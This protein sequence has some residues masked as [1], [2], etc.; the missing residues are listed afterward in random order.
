M[1]PVAAKAKQREWA[2]ESA[3]DPNRTLVT[4]L[5]A[6]VQRSS[7][8]RWRVALYVKRL[9]NYFL[10]VNST[11]TSKPSTLEISVSALSSTR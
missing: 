9:Q 2:I 3:A 4:Q 8:R 10:S 5:I 1:G 6:A 7:R 11:F